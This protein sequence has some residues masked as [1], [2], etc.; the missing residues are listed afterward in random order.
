MVSS[1]RMPRTVWQRVTSIVMVVLRWPKEV[2][3]VHR[4][5]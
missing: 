3:M 2:S 5:L 4:S 1:L